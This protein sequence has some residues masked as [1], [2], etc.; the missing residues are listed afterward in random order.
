MI[1]IKE[2]DVKEWSK[3]GSIMHEH[4]IDWTVDGTL[5]DVDAEMAQVQG[6]LDKRT[7]EGNPDL[8]LRLAGVT[9]FAD[10]GA[11]TCRNG[12]CAKMHQTILKN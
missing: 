1:V 9:K 2:Y 4:S 7:E 12:I 11:N 3:T 8:R 6:K 10:L 5:C